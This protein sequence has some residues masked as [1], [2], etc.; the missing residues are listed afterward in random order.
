MRGILFSVAKGGTH[1]ELR[2]VSRAPRP[3]TNKQF[4]VDEP[5]SLIGVGQAGKALTVR[6]KARI[7]VSLR[8]GAVYA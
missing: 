1:S 2:D 6:R 4:G 5:A 7:A 8:L 3:L